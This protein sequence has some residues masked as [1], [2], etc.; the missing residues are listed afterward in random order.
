MDGAAKFVRG[1]AVAGLVI[2]FINGIGGITIGAFRHGMPILQAADT[3]VRLTVGDGLVT[4]IPA[5]LVSVAAGLLVSK[6]N[7]SGSTDKALISQLGGY[8][9]ALGLSSAMLLMLA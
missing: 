1:D 7:V 8:P 9:S 5:L 3:Y 6:T 2:T 4:Q